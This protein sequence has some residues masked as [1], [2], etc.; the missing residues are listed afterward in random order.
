MLKTEVP[1]VL[2]EVILKNGGTVWEVTKSLTADAAMTYAGLKFL[3]VGGKIITQTGGKVFELVKEGSKVLLREGKEELKKAFAG[4]KPAL[5]GSAARLPQTPNKGF[6]NAAF[7][8]NVGTGGGGKPVPR[9]EPPKPPARV[10]PTHPGQRTF[11]DNKIGSR[12]WRSQA[13]KPWYEDKR[14]YRY[15][16][17]KEKFEFEV[18]KKIDGKWQHYGIMKSE[19]PDTGKI[20]RKF[21]KGNKYGK[22]FE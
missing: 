20:L 21:A 13:R 4:P 12:E 18:G 3:K 9:P 8:K 14:G 10:I 1:K 16:P 17:T 2:F 11:I 15:I 7:S 6:P 22:M 5:A 19:G